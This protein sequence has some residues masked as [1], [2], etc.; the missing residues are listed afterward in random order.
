RP[1]ATDDAV[2]D[3]I[4]RAGLGRLASGLLDG[5]DTV[6]GAGG[7]GLSGGERA[8]LAIARAHLSGRPVIA[9]DEPVA[10]LD[11]PT[12]RSVL[13]DLLAPSRG[14]DDRSPSVVLVTH[15]PDGLDLVDR[16][17]TVTHPHR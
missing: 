14:T 2:L 8:R 9:L 11:P 1:G 6:L 16:V 13:T 7:R 10:H 5:L 15:R 17:F 4:D 12:A 3:A